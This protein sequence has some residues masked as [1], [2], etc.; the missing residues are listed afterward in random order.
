MA[1]ELV[2]SGSAPSPCMPPAKQRPG[3]AWSSRQLVPVLLLPGRPGWRVCNSCG[4][5]PVSPFP[6]PVSGWSFS[7]IE[8]SDGVTVIVFYPILRSSCGRQ[9]AA[10]LYMSI[11]YLGLGPSGHPLAER[12]VVPPVKASR[13]VVDGAPGNQGTALLHCARSFISH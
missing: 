12:P 13:P 7:N 2:G 1:P 3:L 10:L 11:S 6:L 4:G 5:L 8:T 9:G